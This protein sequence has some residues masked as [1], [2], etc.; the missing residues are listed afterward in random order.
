MKG[1]GLQSMFDEA[2]KQQLTLK[3]SP[4]DYY[5]KLLVNKAKRASLWIFIPIM[6]IIIAVIIYQ[7]MSGQ[8][9]WKEMVLPVI[10]FSSLLIA[11][12]ISEHWEYKPWQG[13][14]RQMERELKE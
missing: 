10:A 14:A 3:G 9:D 13:G 7:D 6:T 5:P 12:P 2:R 4:D 11:L 1:V 8:F